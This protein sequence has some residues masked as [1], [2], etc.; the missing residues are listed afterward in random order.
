MNY[1]F[2]D[3]LISASKEKEIFAAE[4]LAEE[5]EM[6]T[7][8]APVVASKPEGECYIE[9]KL[10]DESDSEDFRIEQD[11]KKSPSQHTVFEV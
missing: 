4:L 2:K 6:R 8:K 7:G 1:V 9:L 11:G 5:L 3:I 10:I